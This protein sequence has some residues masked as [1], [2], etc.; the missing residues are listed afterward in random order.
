MDD[1]HSGDEV[2]WYDD[3]V[4]NLETFTRLSKAGHF[5]RANLFFERKLKPYSD[6]IPVAAQ[7]A[8]SL[9]D[10]GAFRAAEEF[11]AN[12]QPREVATG[13]GVATETQV[14]T[15]FRLMLTIAQLYT[16]FEPVKAAEVALSAIEQ[17]GTVTI[18]KGMSQI[19][20]SQ[21]RL[22]FQYPLNNLPQLQIMILS[23]RI[24]DLVRRVPSLSDRVTLV[25]PLR[26]RPQQR[27]ELAWEDAIIALLTSQHLWEAQT[28][29][30]IHI[31]NNG[32][33]AVSKPIDILDAVPR[34]QDAMYMLAYLTIL[35]LLSKT[36][37]WD[38][39]V[40]DT[41]LERWKE[42]HEDKIDL[43]SRPMDDI[44]D[45]VTTSRAYQKLIV[46]QRTTALAIAKGGSGDQES[47]TNFT[48][49]A[50]ASEALAG[51][52]DL[53]F[54]ASCHKDYLLA[55]EIYEASG[56]VLPYEYLQATGAS[57]EAIGLFYPDIRLLDS[58]QT[59]TERGNAE[60]V[61][62][63]LA[64][65]TNVNA[66]SGDPDVPDDHSGEVTHERES[67]DHEESLGA[68]HEVT[69][70]AVYNQ[71]RHRPET[72]QRTTP[73]AT[74]ASLHTIFSSPDLLCHLNE[75]DNAQMKEEDSDLED[76]DTIPDLVFDTEESLGSSYK[77]VDGLIAYPDHG[78]F[79]LHSF[80]HAH[81]D[82]KTEI[83]DYEARIRDALHV[84][85]SILLVTSSR[86]DDRKSSS[87]TQFFA[88][89]APLKPQNLEGTPSLVQELLQRRQSQW[90]ALKIGVNVLGSGGNLEGI[91]GLIWSLLVPQD[92]IDLYMA[93]P[94]RLHLQSI[95]T[96]ES[97]YRLEREL[98]GTSKYNEHS[99][100]L[101]VISYG[102]GGS[103]AVELYEITEDAH[104]LASSI[105][106]VVAAKSVPK[107]IL[108]SLRNQPRKIELLRKPDK[109]R[110]FCTGRQP[111]PLLARVETRRPQ[112][113][114]VE[115]HGLGQAWRR[116]LKTPKNSSY[117]GLVATIPQMMAFLHLTASGLHAMAS[118]P[119]QEF[120]V[121][122]T[123]HTS[124]ES[125]QLH[126]GL[127]VKRG[128]RITEG[129]RGEA[130]PL[131]RVKV[132]V[133]F[134]QDCQWAHERILWF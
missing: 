48:F 42:S 117:E 88:D 70:E 55:M 19:N 131:N 58:L 44:T 1:N 83:S 4:G 32:V 45:P 31:R 76:V 20:V 46:F 40:T 86:E 49:S 66:G 85:Q 121:P 27:P 71:G 3:V 52:R 57:K 21:L 122:L 41:H 65:G 51:L 113:P 7:Y 35:A 120:S 84:R 90:D 105:T 78:T 125:T 124:E 61:E 92:V 87:A 134:P 132:A 100:Y 81:P 112:E 24:I 12:Y 37:S 18:G 6:E 118:T 54:E 23:L 72:T 68:R 77:R 29:L 63:L 36:L 106:P 22:L 39:S 75:R 60:M 34:K 97:A 43:L 53:R 9:I 107:T 108:R 93:A 79:E 67:S 26:T 110:Y 116:A 126:L 2:V 128:V 15:V 8:D 59:A 74:M 10:Q 94:R 111:A 80:R 129:P 127:K 64:A 91:F 89:W 115:W 82:R 38:K 11:L 103:G 69:S 50:D 17:A 30:T 95:T 130:H 56:D 25:L 104:G 96:D 5:E 28:L 119:V 99:T 47:T 62:N 73:L 133:M 98:F 33:Q 14:L 114:N 13:S 123:C 102:E 109:I 16:K 101:T